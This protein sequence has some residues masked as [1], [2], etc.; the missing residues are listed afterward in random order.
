MTAGVRA[1]ALVEQSRG[2][3]RV[4]HAPLARDRAVR[5]RLQS[6]WARWQARRAPG[7]REEPGGGD[8]HKH[9]FPGSP[10]VAPHATG[11]ALALIARSPRSGRLLLPAPT[12]RL[13]APTDGA[14]SAASS[15]G[16]GA[17][18]ERQP[19]SRLRRMASAIRPSGGPKP[20]GQLARCR[21]PAEGLGLVIDQGGR[22]HRSCTGVH[23]AAHA[24]ARGSRTNTRR[25]RRL[26]RTELFSSCGPRDSPRL[27]AGTQA[28]RA[29]VAR[30]YAQVQS[31]P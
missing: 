4:G 26:A 19:G 10:R 18:P 29:K 5:L 20:P 2:D 6:C 21:G 31:A 14:I 9:F 24:A 13:P 11:R 30:Q 7:L 12:Q 17:R 28:L 22:T 16:R 27:C 23:E 3:G 8:R 15:V 1:R 25:N